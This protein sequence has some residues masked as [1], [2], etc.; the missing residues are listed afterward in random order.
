MKPQQGAAVMD[1]EQQRRWDAWCDARIEKMMHDV[2]TDAIAEFV[3]EYVAKQLKAVREE[4]A[5][6]RADMTV[7]NAVQRG[8][9]SQLRGEVPTKRRNDAA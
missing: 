6:L 7:Q 9:I 3:S 1:A 5:G 4:I 2:F 8:E